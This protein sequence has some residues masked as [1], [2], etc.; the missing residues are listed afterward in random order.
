[1]PLDPIVAEILKQMAEM[2]MPPMHEMPP[3]NMR[4]FYRAANAENTRATVASVEDRNANGVP[5]RVYRP[6][7]DEVLPCL[8]FFHG[9]G[10]VIGD[11]ETH[12]NV[13]RYLA[14]HATCVVVAVDYRL[15]PE[16]P[17]PAALDD[18]FTATCWVAAQASELGIDVTK[19]AVGGDSAGGNLAATV[20]I[21]A[22][23]NGGPALVH[24]LLVYPVTDTA[25][26]T[27]S[28]IENA[29]G[30][31]LSRDL[32]RVFWD[33]YIGDQPRDNPMMAPLLAADLSGVPSATVITAEFDPLRD[34]GEAFGEKLKAAGIATKV[35]RY[36]G[37]IHGFFHM[38][39]ALE[40]GRAAMQLAA[41]EL[42]T[43]FQPPS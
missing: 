38:Q 40:A 5:V 39:D 17:F 37:M 33:H 43:A 20:C 22:R 21:K 2:D 12:D 14:L 29:E 9:G 42:K 41:T 1:M 7:L 8:V 13:C 31:S 30:Y 6:V 10:W 26:D 18:C 36:D 3:A 34:E 25:L 23:Q 35:K 4:E 28:Y 15:A 19:I 27:V 11:L 16:H 32:M 24:Q